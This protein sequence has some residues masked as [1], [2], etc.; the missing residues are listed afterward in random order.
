MLHPS[1][2]CVGGV[3]MTG[4]YPQRPSMG[5]ERFNIESAQSMPHKQRLHDDERK[6]REVLVVDGIELAAGNL[7][8][9]GGKLERYDAFRLQEDRKSFHEVVDVWNVGQN[10]V[11]HN[12]VGATAV[13]SHTLRR[14]CSEEGRLGAHSGFSRD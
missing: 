7:L 11:G 2:S 13:R 10:I 5:G 8:L 3:C 4:E 1:G 12:Q 6:I 14:L 9:Q